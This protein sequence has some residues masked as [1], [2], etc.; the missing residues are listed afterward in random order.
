MASRIQ[1]RR[2]TAANW[3]KNNPLLMQGEIGLILDSPNLYKMGD[4]STE[5]NNLPISGFNGNILEELGN[6]AN[7]VISQDLSMREFGRVFSVL[8]DRQRL[9]IHPPT[10]I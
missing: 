1:F 2:D 7:A 8:A 5:W 4:G 10:P 9:F 3:E 6:D